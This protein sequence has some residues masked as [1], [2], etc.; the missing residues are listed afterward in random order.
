M[1]IKH[2]YIASR[3]RKILSVPLSRLSLHSRQRRL[4]EH[5]Q[6]LVL[7]NHAKELLF[8]DW[9]CDEIIDVHRIATFASFCVIG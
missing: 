1:R 3:R 6:P 4:A 7:A 2:E 5:Q 8:I 9:L